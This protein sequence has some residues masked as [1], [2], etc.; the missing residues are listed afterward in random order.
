MLIYEYKV[1]ARKEQYAAIDNAIRTVQFIRNKCIR[2]WMDERGVSQNDLQVYCSTLASQFPFAKFLNSQARQ[3]SAERA[4]LAISRFYD[5]CKN[6]KPGKKGYGL[7]PF[8]DSRA[9]VNISKKMRYTTATYS[10][11][12]V[13]CEDDLTAESS[14]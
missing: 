6:K 5:N 8:D 9:K 13:T 2:L 7:L 12:D 11:G 14:N 3:A 1:D 10:E 4:W